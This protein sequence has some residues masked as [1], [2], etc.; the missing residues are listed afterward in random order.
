[1]L[2]TFI[3]TVIILSGYSYLIKTGESLKCYDCRDC[4]FVIGNVPIVPGCNV[5]VTYFKKSGVINRHCGQNKTEESYANKKSGKIKYCYSDLCNKH[6]SPFINSQEA[7][8]SFNQ[9]YL[10]VFLII[11]NV[12]IQFS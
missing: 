5:C 6:S 9:P 12:Y 11:I 1:M 8:S 10:I 7:I 3:R 2:N 4:F